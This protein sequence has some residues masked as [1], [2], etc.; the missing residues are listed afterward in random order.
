MLQS[1]GYSPLKPDPAALRRHY[2]SLPEEVLLD[3]DRA[4]LTPLAQQVYD[5]EL[6]SRHL[7]TVTGAQK[8]AGPDQTDHPDDELDWAAD[9]DWLSEA[10]CACAFDNAAEMDEARQIL[11]KAEIL[12]HGRAL[13]RDTSPGQPARFDY[14]LMVPSALNLRAISVLDKE[15]FNPPVEAQWRAHFEVLSD[16]DFGT[17]RLEDLTAGM[18]DRI[19]RLTAA[20]DDERTRR[21][22]R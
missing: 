6:A 4:E 5:E 17:L 8:S 13:H 21:S 20:F 22:G 12:C 11:E 9:P 3:M 16:R 1:R 15:L 10:A 7:V 19:A 2:A 18:Q 14:E